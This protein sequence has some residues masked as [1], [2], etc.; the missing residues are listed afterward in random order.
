MA[1][2][3]QG[4][5]DY[6]PQ[7]QPFQPDFNFF[8]T[9]LEQK[10]AQYQAGYNKISQVYGQLLNSNL[11]R[12]ANIDRRDEL[13]TEIDSEIQRL[14]GVDLSLE[15]NVKTA[16]QLFQ[17]LI[18]NEYFRK[19]LAYTKQYQNAK[20]KQSSLKNNPNPKSDERAWEVGDMAL[21]YQA[22]DFSKSSDEE[23]LR[24]GSPEYV[25]A[26]DITEKL[27]KFAKDNDI[28]PE[29]IVRSGGYIFKYTNG[30]SA[31]S[32]LQ[33]VFNSILGSDP[34]I[35]RM[36]TTQ[37]YVDRK[38]YMT[39]NADK[40]DGDERAAEMEYLQDKT[41]IINDYYKSIQE[42]TQQRLDQTN[43]KKKVIEEKVNKEGVDPDIDP[44][45]IAL[46]EG[47]KNDQTVLTGEVD[48]Q[49]EVL[50]ST[51]A[52]D[53]ANTD[54]ESL[55]YRVD[56]AMS[57]FLMDQASNENAVSYATSKQ[58]VDFQVDQIYLEN[59]SHSHR[60]A[61]EGMRFENDKKLK[62]MDI[63]GEALKENGALAPGAS[64]NPAMDFGIT[65]TDPNNPPGT[66]GNVVQGLDVANQNARAGSNFTTTGAGYAYNNLK[67]FVDIQNAIISN[68]DS[69]PTQKEDAKNKILS[70]GI[71]EAENVQDEKRLVDAPTDWWGL[72]NVGAGIA[73]LA[74]A[75]V[76][77]V[78]GTILGVPTAGLSVPVSLGSAAA[79]GTAGM[80]SL[81]F[82]ANQLFGNVEVTEPGYLK[83]SKGYV[84]A[85]PDGT[86]K[87]VEP[88][89]I[90]GFNDPNSANYFNKVNEAIAAPL[91]ETAIMYGN[92][93]QFRQ[94]FETVL[95]NNQKIAIN[96][97][98]ADAVTT[99]NK[100]NMVVLNN[101]LSNE[102]GI[103]TAYTKLYFDPVRGGAK[104][105]LPF[106]DAYA[107][108]ELDKNPEYQALKGAAD[109]GDQNAKDRIFEL[110][111]E[112][113]DD[114][115]DVYEDLND[116]YEELL[117][118]PTTYLTTGVKSINKE[119]LEQS[120]A[121][122]GTASMYP[123]DA[124]NF[125]TQSFKMGMDMYVNDI[126]PTASSTALM[127]TR[128]TKIM[129]GNAFDI[130][131]E[132]F[133]DFDVTS[134]EGIQA[135]NIMKAFFA[136]A[137]TQNGKMV[138]D[139]EGR[140]IGNIYYHKIAAGQANKMAATLEPSPDWIKKFAADNGLTNDWS[141]EI[142]NGTKTPAITFF[143]DADKATS[144]PF[145][146]M[147]LTPEE[148]IINVN[149]KLE[150]NAFSK[151][152]GDITVTPNALG[153]YSYN[154][155]L[156]SYDQLGQL[157]HNPVFGDYNEGDLTSMV[158]FLTNYTQTVAQ[159][160]NQF[161]QTLRENSDNKINSL[162]T[163]E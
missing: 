141:T 109:N 69:S 120:G 19:D 156:K 121:E 123:F 11:M 2:Y 58:K 80:T 41:R 7:I 148:A 152:G 68:P 96:S 37:A 143:I 88:D 122:V 98:A 33:N 95:A 103:D 59:L 35:K 12:Q 55:R 66:P 60:V 81:A 83:S 91:K 149:G 13:F 107:Q 56:N 10:Q 27:F 114:A 101:A 151:D 89:K 125:D 132:D 128:G 46:Y 14:S 65:I 36:Y 155:Y 160:N 76:I 153:G 150:L 64:I 70:L 48:K 38:N 34:R 4:I 50:S 139:K 54:L 119:L 97:Q 146:S 28:N 77:G 82:G 6:I 130:S 22:S 159:A 145:R 162:N 112:Y 163:G 87:L 137:M 21:E 15:E 99:V 5:Q 43:T 84:T 52:I 126:L 102:S 90:A 23:S 75:G 127:S 147:H 158:D 134:K 108:A 29:S 133:D 3:I 51:D 39:S 118:S 94:A 42:D 116:A 16:S 72:V 93:P 26:L 111:A 74:A 40:F 154:G 106:K 105:F 47:A 86:F 135:T 100:E 53:F 24:F 17:P 44:D 45:L 78:G 62:L 67:A 71:Y 136:S 85:N 49:K 131:K 57:Y 140:A 92:V 1:T 138:K 73:S 8:Q 9:A 79:L 161:K 117:K 142:A 30:A 129:F 20:A 144:T 157:L 18:D 25:P 124:Y 61:L 63:L 32:T 113:N 31:V 115:E 110:R 104:G